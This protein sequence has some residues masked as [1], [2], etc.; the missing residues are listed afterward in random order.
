MGFGKCFSC[1]CQVN[2]GRHGIG[3]E[4]S[5][6]SVAPKKT[7]TGRKM[8]LRDATYLEC[9]TAGMGRAG[10]GVQ[11]FIPVIPDDSLPAGAT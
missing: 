11:L 8:K 2:D 6:V 5:S 7:R 4:P 9:P 3:D 1:S 10:V